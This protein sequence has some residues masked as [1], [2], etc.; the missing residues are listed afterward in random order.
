ME[1]RDLLLTGIAT[2]TLVGLLLV[3]GTRREIA[4]FHLMVTLWTAIATVFLLPL[5][6]VLLVR[7]IALSRGISTNTAHLV[8]VAYFTFFLPVLGMSFGGNGHLIEI[9]IITFAGAVGGFIWSMPWVS[10]AIFKTSSVAS[11]EE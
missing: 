9:P 4:G 11:E 6:S 1:S 8:F 10:A 7:V 2:G 5:V 3:I